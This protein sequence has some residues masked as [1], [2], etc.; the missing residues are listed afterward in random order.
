MSD[1][2]TLLDNAVIASSPNTYLTV[3]YAYQRD[4]ANMKY[5]IY[6]YAK[7]K[8][9]QS[10][11]ND[12]VSLTLALDGTTVLDSLKWKA[13]SSNSWPLTYTNTFTVKNKISGST[14]LYVR[15][16]DSQGAASYD[17]KKT[18]TNLIVTDAFPI[19][20]LQSINTEINKATIN[21]ANTITG[22]I[23]KYEV[24]KVSDGTVVKSGTLGSKSGNIELTDLAYNTNYSGIYKVRGYGNSGWGNYL[25]ITSNSFVTK[26]LPIASSSNFDINSYPIF[27]L[28]SSS[29]L[30]NVKVDVYNGSDWLFTVGGVFTS[31]NLDSFANYKDSVLASQ[32]NLSDIPITIK[33]KITSNSKDYYLSDVVVNAIIGNSDYNPI[34]NENNISYEDTNE[35]SLSVTGSK[36]KIIKG[37]SNVKY[38]ITPMSAQGGAVGKSYTIKNGDQITSIDY[39]TENVMATINGALNNSTNI[40][41]I[42]SRNKSTLVSK[43]FSAFIEYTDPSLI[44]T[45]A[46]RNNGV[47]SN[48]LI[49]L[50]GVFCNWS[51][52]EKTNTIKHIYY[53]YRINDGTSSPGDLIEITNKTF[54]SSGT[55]KV[56]DYVTNGNHFDIDTKYIVEILVE[57]LLGLYVVSTIS[58]PIAKP[59][60]WKDKANG[61]IGIGKKPTTTLDVNG[62]INA[63]GSIGIGKNPTTE[64]DVNGNINANN[65]LGAWNDT[66][67]GFTKGVPTGGTTGQILTK[68]SDTDY[69]TEWSD[70]EYLG[71]ITGNAKSGNTSYTISAT[72]TKYKI[73]ITQ[74]NRNLSEFELEDGELVYKGTI[75]KKVL[76]SANS[77]QRMSNSNNQLFGISITREDTV[78]STVENYGI[79]TVTT[80]FISITVSPYLFEIHPGDKLSLNMRFG[81]TGTLTVNGDSTFLTIQECTPVVTSGSVDENIYYK[82]GDVLEIT[83]SELNL[84]GCVTGST[85]GLRFS[86]CTPKLLNN[87]SSITV[88]VLKANTRISGGGYLDG[89]AF[90]SGGYDYVSLY[91][92][93][94][95]VSS[96]NYVLLVAEKSSAFS[97]TTNNIPVCVTVHS[98]KLIF[99]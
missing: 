85:K 74:V 38:T 57:D 55:F 13:N 69:D 47:D 95:S 58:I 73:P 33:T 63:S 59:L 72:W 32:P 44:S 75:A 41:A 4:G 84:I 49:N 56:T 8:S 3:K 46:I 17:Y 9:S 2:I 1:Y 52:L 81:A 27:N 60:I 51:G 68:K 29:Y 87:I 53:R 71:A 76:I 78:V 28:S 10:Y 90:T 23:E 54:P 31:K 98:I 35:K 70:G 39:S 42:D 77:L 26:N 99:N 24:A 50:E 21:I 6:C 67:T 11:R 93:S 16:W 94:A 80:T 91:T 97:G 19:L 79:S 14:S 12:G 20:G 15:C 92:C 83:G 86:L 18:F 89:K 48:L 30:S 7:L 88:E 65:Y 45:S 96:D 5:K 22:N 25:T 37:I 36:Y 40:S 64:L 61:F 82:K 62:N 43:S 66:N 34:F